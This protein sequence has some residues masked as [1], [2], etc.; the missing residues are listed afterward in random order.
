MWMAS[1]ESLV[2]L[3]KSPVGIRGRSENFETGIGI[4][5]SLRRREKRWCW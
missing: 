2:I 1:P 5:P 4:K 3:Q